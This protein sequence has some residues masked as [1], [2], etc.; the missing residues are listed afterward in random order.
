[1]ELPLHTPSNDPWSALKKFTAARIALGRTGVSI[2]VRENLSFKLAH[3]FARDAV[4]TTLDIS[5]ISGGL[6]VLNLP[7]LLLHSKATDRS[8]YLQ[9][10]DLGRR[11]D[12]ASL[13]M[14]SQHSGSYDI[15]VSLADGLSAA[16]INQHALPLL[17]LLI[18]RFNSSG[19]S[20]AP[21]CIIEQ[22][23]VAISDETGNALGAKLSIILIG[24]RPGLSTP[25]SMGAYLTYHPKVGNT[26]H[27][28]N[29]ISNIGL[30]GLPF[31]EAADKI[32]YLVR[33]SL[34][35]QLSGVGLKDMGE[36]IV[37]INN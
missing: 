21:I 2:P 9:R 30:K 32:Y 17:S 36:S 33:E 27:Q 20:I 14:L 18:S 34:R 11:L 25:D 22:G 37:Q 13:S 6:T 7:F 23:R 19:L 4:Y 31:R 3:A 24:E 12:D 35:L 26:D 15:A 8:Q 5:L 29:C 1:M 10:P 16:A 28:R